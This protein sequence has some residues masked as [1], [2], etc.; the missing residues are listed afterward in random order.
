MLYSFIVEGNL[1]EAPEIRFTPTGQTVCTL[2]VAHNRRRRDNAGEWT[3]TTPMW[4]AVTCWGALAEHC[5]DFAKGDTVIVHARDD[6]GTH[7]Y[8]RTDPETS[9]QTPAAILQVT[10]A[11]VGLSARFNGAKAVPADKPAPADP[12]DPTT[13]PHDE[14]ELEPAF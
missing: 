10:A 11:T 3:D 4:I 13:E 7:A 14:R 1:A 9:E 5:A 2:K 12:W 8:L 6:L